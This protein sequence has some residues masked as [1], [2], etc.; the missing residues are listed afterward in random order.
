MG[1]T[2]HLYCVY[3]NFSSY[4]VSFSSM[5][6]LEMMDLGLVHLV[7]ALFHFDLKIMLVVSVA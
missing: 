3:D 4:R 1:L 2:N 6:S 5:T 7:R